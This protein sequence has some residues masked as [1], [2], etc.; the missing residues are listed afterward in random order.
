MDENWS[1]AVKW[2][3]ADELGDEAKHDPLREG[4]QFGVPARVA[5]GRKVAGK[6]DAEEILRH[7]LWLKGKCNHLPRGLDYFFFDL[8][9]RFGLEVATR[10]LLWSDPRGGRAEVVTSSLLDTLRGREREVIEHLDSVT[11]RSLRSR[12]GWGEYKHLWTNR[13]N[14]A[15]KRAVGMLEGLEVSCC[16]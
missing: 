13:A 11:R 12:S 16:V 1:Q 6:I 10:W 9:H 4:Q 7:E 3:F 2:L 8:S 15:K 14:R 5:A